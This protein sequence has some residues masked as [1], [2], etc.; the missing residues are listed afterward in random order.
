M[1]CNIHGD[2]PS[3]WQS[4]PYCLREN[5]KTGTA[6]GAMPPPAVMP[7]VGSGQLPPTAAIGGA[8]PTRSNRASGG[9]D[10]THNRPSGADVTHGAQVYG[11][12]PVAGGKTRIID[13]PES[14]RRRIRAWLIQKDGPRP[15]TIY[16]IKDDETW[17]GRDRHNH[18]YIDDDTISAQHAKLWV[19]DRR[20][21]RL[22]NISTSN[23]TRVNGVKV[24]APV[25][26]QE[27]DE[28][29]I[30]TTVLVLKRLDAPLA[31]G[32]PAQP[33]P[34]PTRPGA[35]RSIDTLDET[36]TMPYGREGGAS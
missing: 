1:R 2:L 10:A 36:L 29:K 28:I 21:L 13:V 35:T 19:D 7:P 8:P 20:V 12:S 14:S 22:L 4:C 18:I 6:T 5:I 33:A 23:G 24:E 17:I 34:P 26:L 3:D 30:G 32:Q 9:A 11:Y 16:Q 27:N 25:E 15:D 31:D